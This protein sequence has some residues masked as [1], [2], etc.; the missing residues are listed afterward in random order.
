MR[1]FPERP[2]KNCT[3]I[4]R[5]RMLVLAGMFLCLLSPVAV[6]P[7]QA[8]ARDFGRDDAN[9]YCA[10]MAD[11]FTAAEGSFFLA[12]YRGDEA[13]GPQLRNAAFSY[14][15][16]LAVIALVACGRKHDAQ[17]IADAFVFALNHDRAWKDGRIRNAYRAGRPDEPEI[18][19]PGWWS[20]AGRRW[21]E[22]GY[23]AGT[24]TGN[25]AW[26]AL[27]LLTVAAHADK[28]EYRATAAKLMSW[29]GKL[30]PSDTFGYSGG[31]H[32]HEPHPTPLTW[33]STEH[34]VDAYA[35][36]QWLARTE[37]N[38]QSGAAA[39]WRLGIARAEGFVSAM[40][41]VSAGRFRIGTALDGATPV[42]TG[43]GLDAQLWPLLAFEPSPAEWR[44]SLQWTEGNHS[45][46]QGFDFDTDK[47][48]I[49]TE[50]TAQAALVYA[51]LGDQRRAE[52]LLAVVRAQRSPNGLLYATDG[53]RLTTG[54]SIGPDS[55]T[56]DFFYHRWPHVGATA[57]AVL[58]AMRW[59]P[60][61]GRG[62]SDGDGV[63]R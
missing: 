9:V 20:E 1:R 13:I 42:N 54:L 55:S 49:W 2:A 60:F 6:Q 48:S 47:D 30:S 28:P 5:K 8:K 50:G 53:E 7:S 14:D 37:R 41:D 27:A 23:Q 15:N 58:A 24:A 32:G 12:S 25:V 17:R 16:A 35:A 46:K 52:A 62:M 29:V 45:T 36:F 39:A 22:D 18:A 31:F 21:L 63:H 51:Y 43:S 38:T 10:A 56:A 40:F 61:T 19:L 11:G 33:K 26:V 44:R 3:A 34:N 57:W 59:N 4:A